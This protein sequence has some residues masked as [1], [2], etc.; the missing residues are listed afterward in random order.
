MELNTKDDLSLTKVDPL[1]PSAERVLFT[2]KEVL[3][4]SQEQLH[5]EVHLAAGP[6]VEPFKKYRTVLL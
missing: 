1:H 2:S 3:H 4:H 6:I 5:L